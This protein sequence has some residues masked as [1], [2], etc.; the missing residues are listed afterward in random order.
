MDEIQLRLL[1]RDTADFESLLLLMS[2]LVP[3]DPVIDPNSGY[4]HWC[5]MLTQNALRFPA[6]IFQHKVVACCA[7]AILPN[8]TRQFRPYA[9]I[10]NVVTDERFR[11]QGFGKRLLRYAQ[12]IAWA[13]GC[14][15][16]ML[17]T[18]SKRASTLNFYER[19]GFS[20]DKKTGFV[21]YAPTL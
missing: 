21:A 15:K 4:D 7:L 13:Q 11:N 10:E 5:N 2:Q 17:L 20:K 18:G 1:T 8:L 19:A 9:L 6:V 3:D 12:D 16:V 14:Y